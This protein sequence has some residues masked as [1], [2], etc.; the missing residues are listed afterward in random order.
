MVIEIATIRNKS[1]WEIIHNFQHW[2]TLFCLLADYL[3]FV[4]LF[5]RPRV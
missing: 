2:K 4:R 5:H 3:F 1:L